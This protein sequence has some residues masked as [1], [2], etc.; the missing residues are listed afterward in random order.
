MAVEVGKILA[1]VEADVSDFVAKMQG[2]QKTLQTTAGHVGTAHNTFN[3]LKGGITAAGVAVGAAEVGLISFARH[4]FS[5]AA[6]VSELNVAIGAIGKATGIGA[7]KIQAATK[8]I[9]DNGIEMHSAQEMAILFAQ[10]NLN[11]ADASRVARVAQDLAVISQSNSTDTAMTLTYAIQTG[12]S[13]LLKSA[14]ITK[15]AS[16][17][18][19]EYAKQLGKSTN[20]L[21]AQERQQATINMVLKEGTKVA[22]IYDAAMQEPGK[23]LR[24]FP[25]LVDDIQESFGT[26]LLHGFGPSIKAAYD[27]TNAFDHAVREGGALYPVINSLDTVISELTKPMVGVVKH[28]SN[29]IKLMDSHSISTKKLTENTKKF[30]PVITAASTALAMLSGSRVLG[31]LPIIGPKI[32]SVFGPGSALLVGMGILI[33]TSPKLRSAFTQML[34]PLQDLIPAI[35]KIGMAMAETGTVLVEAATNIVTALAGPLTGIIEGLAVAFVELTKPVLALTV[36]LASFAEWATSNATVVQALSAAVLTFA[37]VSLV[38]AEGAIGKLIASFVVW[39]KELM[40]KIQLIREEGAAMAQN[41]GITRGYGLATV[42]A[43][44]SG[45]VAVEG[46]G[47]A[48]LSSLGPFILIG[49]AIMGAMKIFSA[50]SDRNK[51]VKARTEELTTAIKE[52][53]KVAADE[54]VAL[55]NIISAGGDLSKTLI[56]TGEEGNKLSLALNAVGLTGDKAS[57]TMSDF[58][59]SSYDASLALSQQAGFG[60]AN[61]K[62]IAQ[63]VSTLDKGSDAQHRQTLLAAGFTEAMIRQFFALEQLDDSAQNTDFSKLIQAQTDAV[64]LNTKWGAGVKKTTDAIWDADGAN[65]EYG[66]NAEKATAYQKLFNEQIDLYAKAQHDSSVI[67]NAAGKEIYNSANAIQKAIADSNDGKLTADQYGEAWM[68]AAWKTLKAEEALVSMRKSL[69]SVLDGLKGVKGNTDRLKDSGI[70]F[71]KML[72]DNA[73]SMTDNGA[74]LADVAAMQKQM[75]AQYYASAEAAGVHKDTVDA[76]LKSLGILD[77]IDS[78]QVTIDLNIQK[79]KDELN[80]FLKTIM[81]TA[82]AL[83]HNSAVTEKY[84]KLLDTLNSATDQGTKSAEW[85]NKNYT[86]LNDT[87]KTGSKTIKTYAEAVK[88]VEDKI[89]NQK[90]AVDDAKRALLEYAKQATSSLRQ[91]VSLTSTMDAYNTALKQVT[92]QQDKLAEVQKQKA[93]DAMQAQKDATRAAAEANNAYAESLGSAVL[94]I[95]SFSDAMNEQKNAFDELASAQQAQD[96]ATVKYNDSLQK[97]A[98]ALALVDDIQTQINNTQGRRAKNELGKLLVKAQDDATKATEDFAKAQQDLQVAVDGTSNATAKQVTWLQSLEKQAEKAKTFSDVM[99]NLSKAGLSRSALSQI[100]SAGA[101]AGTKM[102]EELLAGG[103]DSIKKANDLV[104]AIQDASSSITNAFAVAI[105]ADKPI[106][107]DV[108][109][110]TATSFFDALQSQNKKATDFTAQVK[111]LIKLGLHGQA[112]EEVLNAGYDAGSKIADELEKGGAT[113]IKEAMDIQDAMQTQAN[114]LAILAAPY[115]DQTGIILAQTL[116]DAFKKKLQELKSLTKAAQAGDFTDF[117][118]TVDQM[119]KPPVPNLTPTSMGDAGT[120]LSSMPQ[121][122]GSVL[123]ADQIQGMQDFWSGL[124]MSSIGGFVGVHAKGGIVTSAQLGIIGEAGPEAIIPLSKMGDMM[125]GA[126]STY[127]ISVNAGMGANGTQ[128]G[129]QI[130]EAIKKYEKSNGKRWRA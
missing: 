50:W 72:A 18:Y 105:E 93:A 111:R 73:S 110:G 47:V 80:A 14:G 97:T 89:K 102:A 112:L 1:T 26:I 38:S 125:G 87:A 79:A 115:F 12:N 123:T 96:D 118:D 86:A 122:E 69:Y 106:Y 27:L 107:E 91:A 21:T 78:I 54:A 15:Y 85:L 113:K 82:D 52:Q 42:Q 75:V 30:L 126:P 29:A 33:A 68:G 32:A 128:I 88:A 129:A 66:S 101:D 76:M 20:A 124:D 84:R 116:L 5:T 45:T 40:I 70:A 121:L 3:K 28:F 56:S 19:A 95:L 60:D 44:T 16:E 57:K 100:A 35:M 46:F 51:D 83:E 63:M 109:V 43:F 24:S 127:N 119:G 90:I 130:V 4:A 53:V 67:T 103:A 99:A 77:S 92:D 7:D 36:G 64:V 9:R 65:K 48:L 17:G 23:V 94:G 11:M 39:G 71:T 22:G 10:G 61:S 6:R 81:G 2:V 98:D 34:A 55:N 108:A 49:V 41:I 117:L 120:Y 31:N 13:M 62:A 74:K 59:K 8:A 37:V 25:R 58:Q 114:D 104:S